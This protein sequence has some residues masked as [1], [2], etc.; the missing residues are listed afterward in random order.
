[1]FNI[2]LSVMAVEELRSFLWHIAL[3]RMALDEQGSPC[4]ALDHLY[5]D[6]AAA[7]DAKDD[8]D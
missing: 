1:M 5:G 3:V 6:V 4:E 8:G 7:L 2:T